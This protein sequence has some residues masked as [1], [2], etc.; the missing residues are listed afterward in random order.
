MIKN[1][2]LI[3]DDQGDVGLFGEALMTVDPRI[4]FHSAKTG[5]KALE[6]L[7][8]PQTVTPDLIFLDINM[9]EMNGWQCLAELKTSPHLKKIPV[10]MYSTSAS[11]ADEQKASNLGARAIHRKPDRFEE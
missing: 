4:Q 1:I 7:R 6:L 9:P 3:D 8:S 10:I 2:L 11:K 5:L